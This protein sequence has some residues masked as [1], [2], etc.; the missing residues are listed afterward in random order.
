MLAAGFRGKLEAFAGKRVFGVY[1]VVRTY[2]LFAFSLVFFR[3][4]TLSDVWYMLTHLSLSLPHG[5]KEL[6]MGMPDHD[7]IVL[8][9]AIILLF[10]Y[11]YFMSKRDLLKAVEQQRA[12]VRWGIYYLFI[13]LFLV[14]GEF[15]SKDFIY[16]Q[17]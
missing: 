11:E 15:G 1:S 12:V 6:R 8:A 13:F 4:D 7:L 17:F 14:F 10:V 16:L 9:G 2:L 5:I 3:L